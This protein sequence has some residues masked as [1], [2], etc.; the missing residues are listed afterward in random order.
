MPVRSSSSEGWD[1]VSDFL[2][3]SA[4]EACALSRELVNCGLPVRLRVRGQ[5]MAPLIRDGDVI[6]VI[7]VSVDQVAVGDVILFRTGTG[8]L[9]H[10]VIER[11]QDPTG[12]RLITRGDGHWFADAPLDNAE[13]LIGRVERVQRGRQIVR[14]DRGLAGSL[15][16]L[17]ARNRAAHLVVR[18][19]GWIWWRCGQITGQR[20]TDRQD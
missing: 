10:R 20:T 9:A 11:D 2:E 18:R 3:C 1:R 13:N 15:G 5:S 6:R 7:P 16:R 17:V 8:L 14:L 19:L 12:V 4:P